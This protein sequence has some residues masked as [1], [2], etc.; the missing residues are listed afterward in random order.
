MEDAIA[1]SPSHPM[2]LAHVQCILYVC[3][4]DCLRVSFFLVS[5]CCMEVK[6]AVAV[7]RT[8]FSICFFKASTGHTTVWYAGTAAGSVQHMLQY[9]HT[10]ACMC[11]CSLYVYVCM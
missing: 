3:V 5:S 9:T 1:T 10:H 2:N 4:Y 8:V 11:I 7:A 6:V